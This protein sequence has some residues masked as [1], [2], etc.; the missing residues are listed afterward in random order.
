MSSNNTSD[1]GNTGL[2]ETFVDGISSIGFIGGMVRCELATAHPVDKDEQGNPSL[3]P[4][5]R[6]I[7][8]P[9]GF[10]QMFN[11]LQNLADKMEEAGVLSRVKQGE[12]DIQ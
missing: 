6:L 4:Y 7:I 2:G 9:Q 10:L 12:E 5:Q 8:S 11:M 3:I 1:A